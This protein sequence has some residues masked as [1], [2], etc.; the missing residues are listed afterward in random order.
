LSLL[1]DGALADLKGAVT[2]PG[3]AI[4]SPDSWIGVGATYESSD[5]QMSPQE[6]HLKN[7]S[8]LKDL[9]PQLSHADA[10]GFYEGF[11]CVAPDRLPVV[12]QV[13]ATGDFQN[14]SGIYV[15]CAMGSRGTVFNELA[16][17]VIAA[18]MFN[19]PIPLEADLLRAIDP[20]RFL[21]KS[22]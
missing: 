12:G 2:G 13:S 6:A 20:S 4:H 10:A 22:R 16:A 3:Y 14:A 18:Q 19:E 15:S 1:C 9:F 8:H 17:K 7:L 21:K 11:R 5:K